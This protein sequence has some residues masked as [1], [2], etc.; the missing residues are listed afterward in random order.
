MFESAVPKNLTFI[1]NLANFSKYSLIKGDLSVLT[2]F[3]GDF[4]KIND[5][6]YDEEKRHPCSFQALKWRVV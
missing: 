3:E 2:I 6:T 5:G 4:F 1:S